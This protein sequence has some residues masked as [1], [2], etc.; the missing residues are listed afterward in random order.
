MILSDVKIK[1]AIREGRLIID[2]PPVEYSPSAVDLRLGEPLYIWDP[3]LV[4]QPGVDVTIDLDAFSYPRLRGFVRE[5]RPERD[6]S[7][8]L[9][10]GCFILG[11]TYE[12][13]GFP[14]ESKLAGRVEGRSSLARLGLA[15]HITAPTIH[16]TFGEEGGTVIT[17]EM[18]NFGPFPIKVRPAKTRI[19]QLIVEAVSAVPESHLESPFQTQED[20][21]A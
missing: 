19:C 4:N 15:V 13:I 5:I 14:L 12:K 17:L 2:P 16:S 6:G 10:P 8:I 21:L 18:N 7:Y 1:E 9:P 3:K 11:H 20:A